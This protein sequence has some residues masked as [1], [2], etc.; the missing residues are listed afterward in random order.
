[1]FYK[2]MLVILIFVMGALTLSITAVAKEVEELE[3]NAPFLLAREEKQVIKETISEEK[4]ELVKERLEAFYDEVKT[5][6]VFQQK[7]APAVVSEGGDAADTEDDGNENATEPKEEDVMEVT[8]IPQATEATSTLE[9]TE[10]TEPVVEETQEVEVEEVVEEEPE[11]VWDGP[12]LNS[13]IGTVEGP[14]GKETY[15]NLPMSRVVEIM[16]ELGFEGEYWV[17]DDGVKMFGDYIMVAADLSHRPKGTILP[18]SLGMA[19]VCD[20][21]GFVKWN[22]YQID[23]AVAW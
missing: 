8:I 9:T 18:T 13:Y 3:G 17:R 1:M 5:F 21:G 23:I 15:Y 11:Y 14:S 12:V 16:H 7:D 19:M 6:G 20:T 10:N 2:R 4:F 22:S